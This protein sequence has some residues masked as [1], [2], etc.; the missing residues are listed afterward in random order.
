MPDVV[1]VPVDGSDESEPAV[2][3]ALPLAQVW[4]AE[5]VLL[6]A[7]EGIPG[8]PTLVEGDVA[9]TITDREVNDRETRLRAL[10]A[11]YLH[12]A[13]MAVHYRVPVGDPA[14]QIIRAAHETKARAV[15]MTTHGRSGFKRW[16]L[17][18][19]ASRVMHDATLPTVLYRPHAEGHVPTRL[20]TILVPVDG[21]E[22]S[23]A[24]LLEAVTLAQA[25]GAS[26]QLLRAVPMVVPLTPLPI[27]AVYDQ[28][29]AAALQSAE[30]YLSDL[31]ES[32]A[33]LDVRTNIVQGDATTVVLHAAEDVD[34][35]VMA[36]HGRGGV[37]RVALGSVSDA[38]IRG[39]PVPVMIV[40]QRLDQPA[41]A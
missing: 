11:R 23:E 10:A 18:S 16:R 5:I 29:N 21:S 34:L 38:V 36:S 17:G 3:I 7:W 32:H 41:G 37:I 27:S 13:G 25:A 20:R 28:A 15:V 1:L 12:P 39:S 14:E 19:V 24:A 8:L 2:Q 40:P 26:L 30:L 33:D 4:N 35:I 31:R 22:R 6:W 9:K